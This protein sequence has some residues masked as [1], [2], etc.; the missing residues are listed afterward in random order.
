[1]NNLD[2]AEKEIEDRI[3]SLADEVFEL[4]EFFSSK[5]EKKRH[6]ILWKKKYEDIFS[7]IFSVKYVEYEYDNYNKIYDGRSLKNKPSKDESEKK[8]ARVERTNYSIIDAIDDCL[9]TSLEKYDKSKGIFIHFF[10]SRFKKHYIKKVYFGE[11]SSKEYIEGKT[12]EEDISE[13]EG[14][15][16]DSD[17]NVCGNAILKC[18]NEQKVKTVCEILKL[19]WGV[20]QKR[21]QELFSVWVTYFFNDLKKYI[22]GCPFWNEEIFEY[23]TAKSNE[24]LKD[25]KGKDKEVIKKVT[26]RD[27][28]GKIG[29]TENDFSQRVSKFKERFDFLMNEKSDFV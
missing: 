6:S 5:K 8:K 17:V 9:R 21:Q 15:C 20:I 19:Q 27:I 13:Y 2:V 28:A 1:M 3:N 4:G 11:K 24:Y 25:S 12:H 18:D 7:K 16:K 23:Y 22:E 10:K 26:Q 14:I 29:L